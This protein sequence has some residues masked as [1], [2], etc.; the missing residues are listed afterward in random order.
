M[1]LC[2]ECGKHY[3]SKF[4]LTR[5]MVIH[6]QESKFVCEDCG[7][8][9]GCKDHLEGHKSSNYQAPKRFACG[10]CA[11]LFVYKKNMLYQSHT[12]WDINLTKNSLRRRRSL[13]WKAIHPHVSRL[14]T[15]RRKRE[16][17]HFIIWKLDCGTTS[18]WSLI[19]ICA[20]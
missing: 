14:A 13:C 5:H 3:M 18:V 6:S 19:N 16:K 9:F 11:K 12:F 20:I 1:H 15:I 7:K 4:S 2:P 10:I 17:D 8:S